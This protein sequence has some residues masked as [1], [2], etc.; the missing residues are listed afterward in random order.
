[1]DVQHFFQEKLSMFSGLIN[2]SS[3][4]P[5]DRI[6]IGP[7]MLYYSRL[8][9]NTFLAGILVL[10]NSCLKSSTSHLCKLY[11][12]EILGLGLDFAPAPK[13]LYI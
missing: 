12:E 13:K 7:S 11:Q 1:M 9:Y 10:L 6:L 8:L 4:I 5:R 2:H 3:L